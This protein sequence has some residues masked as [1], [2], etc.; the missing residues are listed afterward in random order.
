MKKCSIILLLLTLIGCTN[1]NE[2]LQPVV[3]PQ[4]ATEAITFSS[5]TDDI[6]V[7]IF[8]KNN[9]LFTYQEQITGGWNEENKTTKNLELGDYKFLYVKGV[10]QKSRFYPAIQTGVDFDNVAIYAITDNQGGYVKPVDEIWLPVSDEANTAYKI[11]GGNKIKQNLKRAVSQIVVHLKRSYYENGIRTDSLIYQTGNIMHDI[12]NIKM[13]IKGV[14]ESITLNGSYG[15]KNM[16][17]SFLPADADINPSTGF[18]FMEGPFAFP[19]ASGSNISIDFEINTTSSN[20][21]LTATVNGPLVKNEK[22][23]ITLWLSP[24]YQTID[25]TVNREFFSEPEAGDDG[26][27]E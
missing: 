3:S 19:N 5:N 2:I 22:L 8:R 10:G 24:T 12:Q 17:Y 13:D 23:E 11:A 9:N 26:I 16:S 1:E 14:G 7:L 4:L 6:S 27:W 15:N 21:P 18:A 20:N 25:V